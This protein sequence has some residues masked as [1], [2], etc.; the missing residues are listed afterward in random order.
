L[1]GVIV[2]AS[3]TCQLRARAARDDADERLRAFLP[4]RGMRDHPQAEAWG[5]LRLLLVRFREMPV[6]TVARLLYIHSS[7]RTSV[8]R[9]V[10]II[11]LSLHV[12]PLGLP[13]FCDTDRRCD[14]Q[15]PMSMPSGPTIDQTSTTPDCATSVFC[16]VVGTAALVLSTP[17]SVAVS[18]SYV[19]GFDVSTFAPTDPQPPL[20]P[21]PQA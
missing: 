20:S 9:F 21:P 11:V 1:I 10:A 16:A 6:T 3:I 7:M 18:G 14:G 8:L 19:V 17:L 12:L 4:V 5:L 15:M 13:L 2:E